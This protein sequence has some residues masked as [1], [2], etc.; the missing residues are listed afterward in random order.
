[1][2]DSDDE[3]DMLQIKRRDHDIAVPADVG[4][5][6]LALGKYTYLYLYKQII[7][8]TYANAE[9]YYLLTNNS[10]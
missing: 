8:L 9:H 2:S 7:Y 5:I 6:D 3:D 4:T 10:I 1:M